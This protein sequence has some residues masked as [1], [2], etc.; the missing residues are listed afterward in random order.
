MNDNEQVFAQECIQVIDDSWAETI[1]ENFKRGDETSNGDKD[2]IISEAF[3]YDYMYDWM[4]SAGMGPRYE[5]DD[6]QDIIEEAL[7]QM[8]IDSKNCDDFKDKL[9]QRQELSD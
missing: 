1:Y 4:D 9:T 6:V 2:V 5:F 3:G 7:Y 8:Y